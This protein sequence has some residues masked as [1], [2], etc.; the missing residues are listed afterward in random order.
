MSENEPLK[1]KLNK[2]EEDLQVMLNKVAKDFEDIDKELVSAR[3]KKADN[4]NSPA[5]SAGE[6]EHNDAIAE[7]EKLKQRKDDIR[8]GRTGITVT[9]TQSHNFGKTIK[10]MQKDV[11]PDEKHHIET[12]DR[13][14]AIDFAKTTENNWWQKLTFLY[15][16]GQA[17]QREA[18]NKIIMDAKVE[19]KGG[20]HH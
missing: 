12:E 3:Q 15:A 16:G 18:A 1:Q 4:A 7:I 6:K 13:Q 9:D 19:D 8:E 10:D 11:I 20:G 17:A 2:S 14:R 5:G